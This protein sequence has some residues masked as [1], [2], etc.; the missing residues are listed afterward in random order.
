MKQPVGGDQFQ[1]N[2]QIKN[3]RN[4]IPRENPVKGL[5]ALPAYPK[6]NHL[7]QAPP[8]AGKQ[9][10]EGGSGNNKGKDFYGDGFHCILPGLQAFYGFLGEFIAPHF[11]C[12]ATFAPNVTI[13]HFFAINY[14]CD[15]MKKDK[16]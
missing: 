3:K 2:Q 5:G 10:V 12:T 14:M 15:F 9:L 16:K 4:K 6:L 8:C 1:E 11:F 7:K 13:R